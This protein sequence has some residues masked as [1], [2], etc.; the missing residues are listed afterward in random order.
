MHKLTINKR[1]VLRV[2]SGIYLFPLYLVCFSLGV[3]PAD[4]PLCGLMFVLSAF[5]MPLARRESRA[6]L[7]VWI[8]AFAVSII[9]GALQIIAT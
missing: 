3:P 1:S 9:F 5:A 2:L 8:G 6:W 7:V 4:L